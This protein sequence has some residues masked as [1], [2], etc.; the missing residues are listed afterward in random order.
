MPNLNP[1]EPGVMFWAGRDE[2]AA[3]AAL[4]VRCGQMGLAGDTPMTEASAEAWRAA[5]D[6]HNLTVVTLFAAYD[7]ERYDDIPTVQATV[8]FVPPATREARVRRTLALSDFAARLGVASV[9]CHV[10]FIPADLSDPAH[11]RVLD[12]VRRV[13]DHCGALG[14]SFALETGQEPAAELLE[15]LHRASRP[16]LGINFDPANMILY[17]TGEPIAALRLLRPRL[18]SVHCK[19][20]LWPDPAQPGALGREVPLG[21]GA[22]GIPDFVAA[23]RETGFTGPLNVERETEDRSARYRDLASGVSLLRSLTNR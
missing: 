11:Q 5:L 22:V 7:G 14:Q 3:I 2:P 9:A 4:G 13:C 1:L 6:R 18:L 15:F 10:G 8:G 16:N 21:E 17:G 23:L 19:D 12:D 20:G